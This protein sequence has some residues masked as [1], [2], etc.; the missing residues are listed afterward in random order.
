VGIP[1]NP[2]F[3]GA[4]QEGAGKFQF[5][6][7]NARRH[8]TAAA[9]LVPVLSRPNLS[10]LTKTQVA[11]VLIENDKAIGIEIIKGNT[12]EKIYAKKK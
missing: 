8:S 10:V 2:D 3:N 9:F 1:A 11:R 5:T 6:I 12:T 7:K 4:Q